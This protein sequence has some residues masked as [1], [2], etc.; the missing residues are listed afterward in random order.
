[1]GTDSNRDTNMPRDHPETVH[2]IHSDYYSIHF[3]S[4]DEA[5]VF[6]LPEARIYDI[7][8]GRHEYDATCYV[9]RVKPWPGMEDSI[10]ANYRAWCEIGEEL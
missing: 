10:R 7:E 1:M 4:D 8:D 3:I 9:V 5:D 6:L 2:I